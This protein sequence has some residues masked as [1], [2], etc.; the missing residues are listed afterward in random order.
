M[1]IG[2][3]IGVGIGLVIGFLMGLILVS[4]WNDPGFR[5]AL[6]RSSS[7]QIDRHVRSLHP[8]LHLGSNPLDVFADIASLQPAAATARVDDVTQSGHQAALPGNFSSIVLELGTAPFAC[9]A[10]RRDER[11]FMSE[12]RNVSAAVVM[13]STAI[14]ALIFCSGIGLMIVASASIAPNQKAEA[15]KTILEQ[16]IES[17]REVRAA[18]AKGVAKPEPLPPITAK[19]AR[20]L[21]AVQSAATI[22][23]ERPKLTAQ[24]RNAFASTDFSAAQPYSRSY[25]SFDRHSA[26]GF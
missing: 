5:P 2:K 19:L 7:D 15:E 1:K 20:D 21:K 17:A 9:V 13:Y 4:W 25:S 12:C 14:V 26:S 11:P 18:L 24:A 23:P 16:R 6:P 22:M 8:K 3:A 10:G